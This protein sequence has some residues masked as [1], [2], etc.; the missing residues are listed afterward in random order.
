M[1]SLI[2]GDIVAYRCASSCEPTKSKPERDPEYV[3]IGRADEL[4]YRICSTTATPEHRIFL[5]S[6]ENFR[7]VLDPNYKANRVSIPKPQHLNAVRRLLIEE[8]GATLCPGYEADD[9][10]GIASSPETIICSIDK[11]L[12]QIEGWHY[13]FVK[14]ET[15]EVDR[16]TAIR[17]FYTQLLTGDSSDNIK[18]IEGIGPVRA[19]RILDGLDPEEMEAHVWNCY[20]EAGHSRDSFV[21]N[22]RLLRILRSM[23]EL[24]E[25]EACIRE[26]QRP[27]ITEACR[28]TYPQVVPLIDGE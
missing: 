7:K 4:L 23:E 20:R 10:I 21:L 6:D 27:D 5:S 14:D 8:W 28:L 16:A 17:N 3:A 9:A 26:G 11:D 25:I 12:R 19:G 18:G 13:N 22:Y 15:T 24:E 1:I 2:D